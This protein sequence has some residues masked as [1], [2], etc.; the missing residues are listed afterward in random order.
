MSRKLP[1]ITVTLGGSKSQAGVWTL[2]QGTPPAVVEETEEITP[3]ELL[4]DDVVTHYHHNGK[5]T[6]LPAPAKVIDASFPDF[7]ICKYLDTGEECQ[8]AH[9]FVTKYRV[10]LHKDV[11]NEP[12]SDRWNGKC[13][14]CGKG[15]YTGFTSIEHDG[16]CK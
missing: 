6:A 12:K 16:P 14:R 7:A 15:T 5:W 9:K 3:T 13:S 11:A 8:L 4:D 10:R 2:Y 1:T